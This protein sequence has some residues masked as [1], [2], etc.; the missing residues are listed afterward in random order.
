LQAFKRHFG[1]F[2]VLFRVVAEHAPNVTEYYRLNRIFTAF[3][4]DLLE[5]LESEKVS[6]SVLFAVIRGFN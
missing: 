6:A 5:L 4:R 2:Y 3:W 1:V